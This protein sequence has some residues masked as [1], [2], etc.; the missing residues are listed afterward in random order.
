MKAI[1]AFI[2]IYFKN[3]NRPLN[4]TGAKRD[5]CSGSSVSDGVKFSLAPVEL[6]PVSTRITSS[7]ALRH[8]G[9]ACKVDNPRLSSLR[10]TKINDIT[11]GMI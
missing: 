6:A 3:Q 5:G 2:A 1:N 10:Q 7:P 11:V 4:G 9:H 8:D